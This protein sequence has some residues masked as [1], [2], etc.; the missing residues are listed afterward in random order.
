MIIMQKGF[1]TLEVIL[2]IFIIS[3]LMTC[4]VPNAARIIDKIS[5]DYETKRLYSDLRFVQALD[6]SATI[7]DIGMQRLLFDNKINPP[8]T[9]SIVFENPI[10][11]SG[12]WQ[13]VRGTEITDPAIREPHYLSYGVK[14]VFEKGHEDLRRIKFD[15]T[16][17]PQNIS[18][19][20]ANGH[21]ILTSR[22]KKYASK[23]VFDTVGRFRGEK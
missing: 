5:L 13:I 14:I 9:A 6:R 21:I 16:G 20:V 10:E 15:I 1:A 2:V 23:I 12:G 3:V 8:Q 4:A 19:S 18:G 17:K 11:N 7:T 22:N